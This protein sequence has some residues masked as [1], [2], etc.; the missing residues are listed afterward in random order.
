[1]RCVVK[2]MGT[3]FRDIDLHA[4][5]VVAPEC[6]FRVDQDGDESSAFK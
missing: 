6:S 2:S 5:R 3:D 4:P 1:M